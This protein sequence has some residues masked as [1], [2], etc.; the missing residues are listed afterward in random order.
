MQME[1]GLKPISLAT[2]MKGCHPHTSTPTVTSTTTPTAILT[3]TITPTAGWQFPS[4]P[5]VMLATV[6]TM[7]CSTTCGLPISTRRWSARGCR[8][9]GMPCR[10]ACTHLTTCTSTSRYRSIAHCTRL[11]PGMV[12]FASS[13][14]ATPQGSSSGSSGDSTYGVVSSMTL[15]RQTSKKILIQGSQSRCD[16]L[17]GDGDLIIHGR[18][19]LI[20]C[21]NGELPF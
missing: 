1:G 20:R 17:S 10:Q 7:T 6:S 13:W 2:A 3:S 4:L 16:N 18:Q 21:T 8:L 19:Q 9:G 5:G 11:Y 14:A 15:C 12:D